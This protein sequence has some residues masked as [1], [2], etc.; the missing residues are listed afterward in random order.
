MLIV[1]FVG[2]TIC[3]RRRCTNADENEWVQFDE[4]EAWHHCACVGV[5]QKVAEESSFVCCQPG[6]IPVFV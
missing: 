2:P 6:T 4:C 1:L 5:T 3:L